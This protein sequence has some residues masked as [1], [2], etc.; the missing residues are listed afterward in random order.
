[1]QAVQSLCGKAILLE[2]GRLTATG[3]AAEIIQT[4]VNKKTGAPTLAPEND[5][6]PAITANFA[7]GFDAVA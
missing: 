6:R 7:D 1:M 3:P 2:R 5:K 4:Y